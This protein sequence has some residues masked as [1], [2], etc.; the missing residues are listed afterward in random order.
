MA[1]KCA[2]V[3]IPY[4]G[5]KGGVVVDPAKLSR[6]EL[7][8]LS[9]AYADFITPIV[10]PWQDVPAPDVNTDGAIMAWMLEAYEKEIGHQAPAT[11][12]GKQIELGGSQGR[13]EATGLGGVEVLKNYLASLNRS[14]LNRKPTLAIQGFGNVGSYFAE[15]AFEAGYKV[16][17]VSNSRGGIYDPKG[18]R[19]DKLTDNFKPNITNAE[20]LALEIDVLV[21]AALENAITEENAGSI[22]A[23]CVLEMANGPTTPA[24]EEIL[25]KKGIDVLP[26]VLCNAGGVTV[27]YFEWAQNL[28]G[29]YWSKERVFAEEKAILTKAFADIAS[30][31][32]R[33]KVSYRQAAFILG[34]SRI[35]EAM[36]LRGRI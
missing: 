23:K 7:K 33:R 21:P 36:K 26:D 18:L 3:G 31:V 35:L 27:S 13:T 30:E 10:G 24:A 14:D 2:V 22:K 20:L 9:Y 5:A 4:G 16:V 34:V 8:R 32:K 11:F 15:Y 25:L 12:T 1:V 6:E 29:Y 28:S 17:A 19:L